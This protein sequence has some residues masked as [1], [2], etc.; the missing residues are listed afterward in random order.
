MKLKFIFSIVFTHL[1]FGLILAANIGILEPNK[2]ELK[3][4]PSSN[5]TAVVLTGEIS[6]DIQ[7]AC[8]NQTPTP[9]ITFTGDDTN[10]GG[11][12]YT[13]EYTYNGSD[14]I[15]ITTAT[16]S[17]SLSFNQLTTIVVS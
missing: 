8:L 4:I 3:N 11:R 6:V 2:A 5:E 13:F 1:V 17:S 9:T 7:E 12:P 10:N 16:N 14:P 15:S